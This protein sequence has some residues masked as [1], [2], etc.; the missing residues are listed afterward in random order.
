MVQLTERQLHV[1]KHAVGLGRKEP[2]ASTKEYTPYRNRYAAAGEYPEWED[3]VNKGLAEKVPDG[4]YVGYYLTRAG[5][6]ALGENLGIK[7]NDESD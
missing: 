6:D 2:D 5:L 7:I 1:M 3:L 4:P